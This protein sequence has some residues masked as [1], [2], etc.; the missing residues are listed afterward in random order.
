MASTTE[1]A[2]ARAEKP[3]GPYTSWYMPTIKGGWNVSVWPLGTGV[4]AMVDRGPNAAGPGLLFAADGWRF[5]KML[6]VKAVPGDPGVYRPE[7]FT[8]SG[9]GKMIQWGVHV[10][11]GE[12]SPPF[13]E[14]FDCQWVTQT[15]P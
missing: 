13:I 1:I 10:V 7:A 11:Y 15:H 6:D 14:R 3:E 9:K 5:S 12:E 4:A 8:D 2:I